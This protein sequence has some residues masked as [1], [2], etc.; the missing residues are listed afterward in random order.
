[1]KTKVEILLLSTRTMQSVVLATRW[2]AILRKVKIGRGRG[3]IVEENEHADRPLDQHDMLTM[4]SLSA[5]ANLQ[6]HN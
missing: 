4:L 2:R 6:K 5:C 3:S 1:M